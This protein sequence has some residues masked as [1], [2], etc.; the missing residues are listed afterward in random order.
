[1]GKIDFLDVI[2]DV[3]PDIFFVNSDGDSQEKRQVIEKLGIKYIVS[4][5]KPKSGL[6]ERSTTTIRKIINK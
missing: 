5:R 2:K 4:E 1:M 3:Q 6:P